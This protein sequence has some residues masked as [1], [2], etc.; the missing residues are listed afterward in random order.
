MFACGRT[1]DDDDEDKNN[2]CDS[3]NGDG[4]CGVGRASV[5]FSG[6]DVN[7]GFF[8]IISPLI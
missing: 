7:I 6:V 4:E 8:G 5:E 3:Q 2:S 1:V